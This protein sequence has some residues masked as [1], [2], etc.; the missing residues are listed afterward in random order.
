MTSL[1]KSII[2]FPNVV[3]EKEIMFDIVNGIK[4]KLSKLAAM[5]G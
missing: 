1:M 3:M 2:D 5:L 4:D